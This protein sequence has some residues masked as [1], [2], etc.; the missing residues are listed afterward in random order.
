MIDMHRVPHNWQHYN[1]NN[2]IETVLIR[3]LYYT[4]QVKVDCAITMCTG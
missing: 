1:K 2:K 4:A 3:H